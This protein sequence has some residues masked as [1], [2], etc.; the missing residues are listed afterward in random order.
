M[1]GDEGDCC[2]PRPCKG[3]STLPKPRIPRILGAI[4]RERAQNH[5][6]KAVKGQLLPT[7]SFNA[8]YSRAAQPFGLPNVAFE[9]ETRVY[10]QL[11]VPLYQ[12]GSVSA[13]IR[14]A[15]ETLSGMRQNIDAQR[16]LARANV[17]SQWGLPLRQKA[18]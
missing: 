6:V 3:Q 18:T 14:Q 2:C 8:S 15:I 1:I 12:A 10:G 13:Q 16:E 5:Q 7:L 17:S 4:F 11:T 9:D